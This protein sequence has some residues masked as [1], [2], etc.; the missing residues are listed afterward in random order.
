MDGVIAVGSV[1]IGCAVGRIRHAVLVVTTDI[2]AFRHE[3][4]L[5][6]VIAVGE[7]VGDSDLAGF[8][9]KEDVVVRVGHAGIDIGGVRKTLAVIWRLGRVIVL[10]AAH[11][12]DTERRVRGGD[13]LAGLRVDLDDFYDVLFRRI[14]DV[15]GN[16]LL[17]FA[18]SEIHGLFH[19]AVAVSFD[20]RYQV[21]AVGDT[22]NID[23]PEIAQRQRVILVGRCSVA[24]HIDLIAMGKLAHGTRLCFGV[25]H[26]LDIGRVLV[27]DELQILRCVI[28]G[29]YVVDVLIDETNRPLGILRVVLAGDDATGSRTF[30]VF[31]GED[32]VAVFGLDDLQITV[33]VF[34][35]KR[36]G[37][38]FVDFI[39]IIP[40]RLNIGV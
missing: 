7:S 14:M 33:P 3:D 10:R 23:L 39:G 36:I 28:G 4:F 12:A 22:G 11:I 32:V 26:D 9:G 21:C 27:S 19:V 37:V 15:G 30:A 1:R 40:G 24:V 38:G 16:H 25:F 13:S 20:F 5:D 31:L 34:V 29:H 35:G 2:V 17:V 8:I 18:D 6:L